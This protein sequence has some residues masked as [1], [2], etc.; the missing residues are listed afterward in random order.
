MKPEAFSLEKPFKHCLKASNHTF[1]IIVIN[2]S[3]INKVIILIFLVVAKFWFNKTRHIIS[4]HIANEDPDMPSNIK[5]S[6]MLVT[7]TKVLPIEAIV[8]GYLAGS[9]WNTYEATQ[10]INGISA[11][12]EYKKYDKFDVPIFTP[13]TKAKVGDKD[14]NRSLSLIH[15]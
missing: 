3:I 5:D 12:K 11:I 4:N 14:I 6:C 9:A 8:R 2:T 15:I 13:S 1:Y 10:K 7:K